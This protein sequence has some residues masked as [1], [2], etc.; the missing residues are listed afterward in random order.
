MDSK[1]I[2]RTFG[3]VGIALLTSYVVS[4]ESVQLDYDY[5]KNEVQPV[6]LAKRE[7]RVRC[8]QCHTRSSNFRLQ[9]LEDHR[10]FFT[11]QQSRMNFDSASKFVLPG[12][13]PLSSRFLTHALATEAGGDPFHGGGKHFASQFDPEWRIMADWVAGAKA[14]RE[15]SSVQVRIIQTNAAS[16]TSTV[17]DP[18]TNSVIGKITDIEIP[19][20]IVGAPD[21][22]QLYITNEAKHS[23][24]I[25]DSRTLRVK[26]RIPLSG[27]PN[28]VAVTGDG[29]R[30]YV[31]IMEMPGTIDVIDVASMQKI[32]SIPVEGA[33]HNV[34]V[35]P[36]SKYAVGGSIQTSTINVIDIASNELAWTLKMSSGVRPM[37]FNANPD[38][39]TKN[40][41][42]Q[43]SGFHGFAVVDF[44][45]RKEI[46]RIEHPPAPG[47]AAHYDGLQGAP[48]HGLGVSPDGKTLWSTS[49]VYSTVYIHSLPDLTEIG[50][51][52]V[53][54]HPEW[55]TF[56]PDGKTAYIG[57]AGDHVTYAVD[58]AMMKTVAKIPVGQV[59][60]RLA[61][62]YMAVD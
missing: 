46:S 28:N 23:L 33:I 3:T 51:V 19:H 40:I 50:Q 20:G 1:L 52:Y 54:Q 37:I 53:G 39:S 47:Q 24:D 26:R 5:F 17:I 7:A 21:G 34:Y 56:T 57:A 35:T 2:F 27:R 29:S 13:D 6:F 45:S 14:R 10:L 49:K 44:A 11:E 16:D 30:V 15:P 61:S 22:S 41:F 55:V 9:P 32:K 8:I 59:P 38:G 12:A 42:V 25:V 58:V 43:L 31:A 18:V 60:K 62:V 48:A 4:Q 36:D